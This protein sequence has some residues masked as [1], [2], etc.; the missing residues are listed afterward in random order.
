MLFINMNQISIGYLTWKKQHILSKTFQSH[1]Q[2]GLFDIIPPENRTV[3]IQEYSSKDIELAEKYH[4]NILK[5]KRNIGILDA[6]IQLVENCKTKYFIFSENDFILMKDGFEI[7]KTMNDVITLLDNDKYGVVKLS[8]SKNPGFLYVKGCPEWLK[9]DQSKFHFKAESLSWIP[10]PKEFYKDIK[11]VIYNYEWFIFGKND[12][13]WSNHIY[14]CNTEFL[15][16]VV[17][18]L[19]KHSRDNNPKLDRRYQG[20]EETLIFPEKIP[21]QTN[22]IKELINLYNQRHIYSG[23][24]NFFHNKK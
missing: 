18:P 6:F 20:L 7:Q 16:K 17:V 24:G 5:D 9:G 8:N 21:N 19:L 4:I 14:A 10:N 15:Q 12:Q 2:N 13:R 22:T 1:K 11:T 23:G 3:F